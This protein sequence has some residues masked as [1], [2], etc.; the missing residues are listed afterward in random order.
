MHAIY[1]LTVTET[2]I[3]HPWG[4][5]RTK[6]RIAVQA[7]SFDEVRTVLLRESNLYTTYNKFEM[8]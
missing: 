7:N 8:C 5:F 1:M 6:R 2:L 3:G 4:Q